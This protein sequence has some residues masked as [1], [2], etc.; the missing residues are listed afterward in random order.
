MQ[1]SDHTAPR[2][3]FCDSNIASSRR[4]H[5]VSS[6]LLRPS[7]LLPQKLLLTLHPSVQRL[8]R[9]LYRQTHQPLN[10]ALHQPCSPAILH[11]GRPHYIHRTKQRNIQQLGRPTLQQRL[12]LYG[13]HQPHLSVQLTPLRHRL[14]RSQL[15]HLHWSPQRQHRPGKVVTGVSTMLDGAQGRSQTQALHQCSAAAHMTVYLVAD[16]HRA[17]FTAQTERYLSRNFALS[18]KLHHADLASQH[19]HPLHPLVF[20]QQLNS[21]SDSRQVLKISGQVNSKVFGKH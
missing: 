20:L 13:H 19:S 14:Q 11:H 7:Q 5:H 9:Q 18:S 6:A 15:Y 3:S 10:P 16:L 21:M 1:K 8:H 12:L 2:S 17:S 4:L